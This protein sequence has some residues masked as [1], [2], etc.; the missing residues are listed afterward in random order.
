MPLEF[1]KLLP[2]TEDIEKRIR[3]N[4]GVAGEMVADSCYIVI[5]FFLRR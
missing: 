5:V 1:K 3:I 4:E 2:S